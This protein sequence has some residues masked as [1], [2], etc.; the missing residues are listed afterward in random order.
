MREVWVRTFL[1]ILDNKPHA[2]VL[3]EKTPFHAFYLDE[4]IAYIPDTKFIHLIRGSRAVTASLNSA[5]KGWG[6]YWARKSTKRSALEWYRHVKAVKSSN[7]AKNKLNYLEVH[8]EDLLKDPISELKNILKFFGLE[9][10]DSLICEAIE[11]QNFSKQKQQDGSGLMSFEGKEIK[12][13]AGFF[14]KGEA[15]S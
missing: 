8:Y 9:Q 1:P 6:Y 7:V 11:S 15:D 12:E 2:T 13:P 14:R 3:L 5:S 4:I 10:D